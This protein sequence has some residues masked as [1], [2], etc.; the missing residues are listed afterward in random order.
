MAHM[1][2]AV[3][4]DGLVGLRHLAAYFLHPM[5]PQYTSTVTILRTNQ[6]LNLNI[7]VIITNL[8]STDDGLS[9][10]LDKN[11]KWLYSKR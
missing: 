10:K 8:S 6:V 2:L 9:I 7:K 4:L 5:K 1:K 11:K 3:L